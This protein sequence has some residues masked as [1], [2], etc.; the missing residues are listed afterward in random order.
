MLQPFALPVSLTLHPTVPDGR[1][2]L[3][4]VASTK[5]L[6]DFI[7][8]LFIAS[9]L[10][11]II[12]LALLH[13]FRP[14]LRKIAQAA[15]LFRRSTLSRRFHSK[16]AGADWRSA[17][18]RALSVAY[19]ASPEWLQA[20]TPRWSLH[21]WLRRSVRARDLRHRT[22]QNW[23]HLR[24]VPERL[25]YRLLARRRA[26]T[27][28]ST[29]LPDELFMRRLENEVRSVVESPSLNP[30]L[31]AIV[32]AT[33]PDAARTAAARMSELGTSNPELTADLLNS[34]PE[35]MTPFSAAVAEAQAS[36]SSA[37]E[38]WLDSFQLS[39]LSHSIVVNRAGTLLIGT[40]VAGAIGAI[41]HWH[42]GA[43]ILLACGLSGGVLALMLDDALLAMTRRSR[44]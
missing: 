12:S 10:I 14:L 17:D 21:H 43:A 4:I 32:T 37:A 24:F 25:R 40:L 34:G 2:Q 1:T 27:L 19:G 18:A 11:G 31:F 42:G 41:V 29:V 38:G 8:E 6:A 9:V 15:S 30:F 5:A 36:V 20:A 44:S 7:V 13:L 23:E 3:Q 22:R 26:F 16:D 39:L 28:R 33:A 35:R